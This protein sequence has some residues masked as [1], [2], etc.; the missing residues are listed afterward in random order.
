MAEKK[1]DFSLIIDNQ[2][3]I[4]KDVR[5]PMPIK[6]DRKGPKTIAVL[7]IIGAILVLFQS[8]QD[9]LSNSLEDISQNDVDRLLETPNSQSDNP[10]TNEQYQQFHDDARDSGGYKIRSI[11]L[12]IAGT[13]LIIGSINLFRLR[14]SGSIIATIGAGIGLLTG[15]YGSYLIRLASEENLIGPLV[16]TY[17]VFVYLCGICMFICGAFAALP[18]VNA[19]AKE[20]FKENS[21]LRLVHD[22]EE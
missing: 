22:S 21:K 7:L 5:Q 20:A 11:G 19:R 6:A 1:F 12:F 8:Y 13:L 2:D 16:F 4:P 14:K 17:E 3:S 18:L 9:Y 10:V 15:V